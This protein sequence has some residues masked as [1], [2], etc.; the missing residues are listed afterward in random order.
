MNETLEL[1]GNRKSVR[2]FKD[3]KIKREDINTII[4]STLRAPTAGGQM[5]YSIIEVEDPILKDKLV[6]TCDNQPFIAKAPLV[7][8]FL[9]DYQRTYDLFISSGVIEYAG[10]EGITHRTP[11]PGDFMLASCDAL[12]AAQTSVLAAESLGL[13]SCYIGDIMENYELHREMF[14]L[15]DYAFPIT[16]LCFGY[17]EGDYSTRSVSPRYPGEYICFKNQYR[18]LDQPDFSQMVRPVEETFFKSRNFTGN[19]ENI[20]Q[21]FYTKKFTSDFT[22]EMN[23]SVQKALDI[24]SGI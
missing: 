20:G 23:R 21:H 1:I 2:N 7:L 13:G 6:V 5:L 14:D 9:A 11:G 22:L 12:I 16:M 10:R 15:P 3:K 8:L 17:P 18:R 4:N 19:S 24:W